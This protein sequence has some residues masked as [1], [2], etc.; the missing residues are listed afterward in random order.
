M[1]NQG[2]AHSA[3]GGGTD[4]G[5]GLVSKELQ[6]RVLEE[7]FKYIL[8]EHNVGGKMVSGQRR[9]GKQPWTS[10]RRPTGRSQDLLTL[11]GTI[12]FLTHVKQMKQAIFIK[13]V[14]PGSVRP[15]PTR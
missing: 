14:T 6:C 3:K 11:L 7:L 13:C 9:M 15:L 1:G 5:V 4:E 10:F 2:K 12:F 8:L